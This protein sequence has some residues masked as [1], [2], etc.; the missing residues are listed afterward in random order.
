[1]S[2]RKFCLCVLAVASAF[3]LTAKATDPLPP[4]Y[5]VVPSFFVNSSGEFDWNRPEMRLD[6]YKLDYDNPEQLIWIT[7]PRASTTP[8]FEEMPYVVGRYGEKHFAGED[9]YDPDGSVD[10]PDLSAFQEMWTEEVFY[11]DITTTGANPGDLG[12]GE[13]DGRV[14]GADLSYFVEKWLA[15]DTTVADLVKLNE[16]PEHT[17]LFTIYHQKQ[18]IGLAGQDA[19]DVINDGESMYMYGSDYLYAIPVPAQFTGWDMD[20]PDAFSTTLTVDA[21]DVIVPPTASAGEVDRWYPISADLDYLATNGYTLPGKLETS[22]PWDDLQDVP[23]GVYI[24]WVNQSKITM[25]ESQHVTEFIILEH[26]DVNNTMLTPALSHPTLAANESSL[27]YSV[28]FKRPFE[29]GAQFLDDAAWGDNITPFAEGTL[30]TAH[31]VANPPSKTNGQIWRE[32]IGFLPGLLGDI[33]EE[34]E[35]YFN[36]SS[37]LWSGSTNVLEE[38]NIQP[39][40]NGL[41]TLETY[42][43]NPA[44][45]E[46]DFEVING[47]DTYSIPVRHTICGHYPFE[48]GGIFPGSPFDFPTDVSVANPSNGLNFEYEGFSVPPPPNA[49]G[50]ASTFISPVLINMMLSGYPSLFSACLDPSF[51]IDNDTLCLACME[52]KDSIFCKHYRPTT[53]NPAIWDT[54][55][56][57]LERVRERLGIPKVPPGHTQCIS[58]GNTW[59]SGSWRREGVVCPKCNN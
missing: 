18:Y 46:I 25:N 40:S 4:T 24:I 43:F 39:P 16:N 47:V 6:L 52:R 54:E 41:I 2:I 12:Y 20:D 14:D 11:A 45:V 32:N 38:I 29:D 30:M 59:R 19:L 15:N 58:C 1:M 48:A 33:H 7:R 57:I 53:V 55:P 10:G 17:N 34:W 37:P 44:P 50:V 9:Y 42:P 56:D 23:S 22:I 27:P 36:A 5:P 13:S 3:T 31:A 21:N 51:L 26:D 28:D 35:D 49:T 8:G